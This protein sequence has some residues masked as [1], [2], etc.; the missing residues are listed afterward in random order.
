MNQAVTLEAIE[1]AHNDIAEMIARYKAQENPKA[2]FPMTIDFPHL[3]SSERYIGTIINAAGQAEHVILL[4]GDN[5]AAT[6]REQMEWAASIGGDLPNRI[7]Q[8]ILF[9]GFKDEFQSAYYWSNTRL[10]G[11]PDYA[12]VQIFSGGYQYFLHK[13]NHYRARAVRRIN[14]LVL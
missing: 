2:A 9:D 11:G 4:P 13:S 12:W 14:A 8:A 10:E 3:N 6:W 5:D 7:E 1:A